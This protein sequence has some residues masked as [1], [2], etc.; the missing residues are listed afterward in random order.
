MLTRLRRVA[1]RIRAFFVSGSNDRDF[2]EELESHLAMMTDEN[3]RRGMAPQAARRAAAIKLGS[4]ASLREQHRDVRGL[5]WLDTMLQDLRFA[6]RLLTKDR[7]FCAAA[8]AAPTPSASPSS[9]A[10]SGAGFRSM[11]RIVCS[12]CRGIVSAA[13]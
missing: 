3:I 12:S 4:P 1:G 9:T 6:I 11:M 8:I 2:E 13:A 5:P 10:R 7:W